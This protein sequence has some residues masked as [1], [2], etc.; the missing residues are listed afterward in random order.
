MFLTHDYF[1]NE[2]HIVGHNKSAPTGSTT[3]STSSNAKLSN[4]IK[5]YEAEVLEKVFGFEMLKELSKN[6]ENKAVKSSAPEKWKKLVNGE[7]YTLNGTKYNWRGLLFSLGGIKKSLLA[8]YVYCHYFYLETHAE[9]GFVK[10]NNYDFNFQSPLVNV[11]SARRKF[12]ELVVGKKTAPTIISSNTGFGIDW[13]TTINKEKSLY[14]YLID[15]KT[16]FPTWVGEKFEN[17]LSI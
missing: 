7:E 1:I 12:I 16:D 14:E 3:D 15:K 4:A 5:E 8:Y 2:L 11:A 6:V 9:K 17:S 10:K 13:T